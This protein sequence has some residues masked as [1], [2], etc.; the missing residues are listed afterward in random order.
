LDDDDDGLLDT[1]EAVINTDPLN[2]DTDGDTFA[3][4]DDNC[5]LVNSADQIDTDGDSE[6]DA[7]DD[8][9]DNDGLTDDLE[10]NLGTNPTLT[11][12][13]GDGDLDPDDNCPVKANPDQAD[14]DQDNQG[15]ECDLDDDNDGFTDLDEAGCG[16]NPRNEL[17]VPPDDDG[18]GV[19]NNVDLCFGDNASGDTDVDNECDNLDIDDDNDN[20][21]DNLEIACGS[22]SKLAN[23]TPPDSDND[24]IC[25][26]LDEC[27]GDDGSGDLDNDGTCNDLDDDD[28]DDG[29]SDE[30]ETTCG[31]NPL[32]AAQKPADTDSDGLCDNGVDVDDDNDGVNDVNDGAP[33]DPQFC[34]DLDGDDCDDC[35][36]TFGPPN[37]ANDGLDT[38]SDG[39]CDV[40]DIDDDD[41]GYSDEDEFT[42]GSNGL[43][44]NSLPIDTDDDGQC[45]NGVDTDDDD[46]GV[47]DALDSARTNQFQCRDFDQDDCDDCSSGI[48][49]TNQDG[50]DTD[51]DGLCNI[52]DLDD[53]GDGFDDFLEQQCESDPL[54]RLNTPPDLD[55]DTVCNKL[56]NCVDV[57]NFDQ[58]DIN[59]NNVGDACD[60]GD[61]QVAN[62]EDCD[63][64]GVDEANCNFDC[65]FAQC[66]DGHQN[67]EADEEC[68]D[69]NLNNSDDCLDDQGGL[70]RNAFCGDSFVHTF[71]EECDDGNLN[72]G[73]GCDSN[74]TNTAC[75]NGIQT[76]GEACDDDNL[77]DGDGCDSNCQFTGC[78]N[79]VVTAGEECD[80]GNLLNRDGCND[81]C[82]FEAPCHR[83]NACPDDLD[84][85]PLDA[86]VFDMGD[87]DIANASP[88]HQVTLNS[89]ELS[90]TEITV[91]QYRACV[92]AGA[93]PPPQTTNTQ[94]QKSNYQLANE[95]PNRPNKELYPMNRIT[96]DEAVTFSDW[97]G[98]RLPTESEWEY[99]ATA[100]GTNRIYAWGDDVPDC[101]LTVM[102]ENGIDGCG[103][104]LSLPVCSKSPLGNT[105]QDLCDLTGNLVEWTADERSSNYDDASPTGEAYVVDINNDPFNDR[106]RRITRGGYYRSTTATQLEVRRRFS[107]TY[108]RRTPFTGFRVARDFE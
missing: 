68:D 14:L 24:G 82:V 15:D 49:N 86:G 11:D 62:N 4:G 12:T 91:G 66:G 69:G 72:N 3:D 33:L 44:A 58:A 27:N 78:G 31:G 96:W 63:T 100:Q 76:A 38:D 105:D 92:D 40:G 13:D 26:A 71:D 80:D 65:T 106:F 61:F 30:D 74:C 103:S 1:E 101:T 35:F 94:D 29:F 23:S 5:P 36:V 46:D 83:V 81:Q 48:S 43:S 50:L 93:C 34:R 99:A 18:D 28:D 87:T 21:D 73:D 84:F 51:N 9:D 79:G 57:S 56:D 42:C 88:V 98:G 60:C 22:N 6:G 108:Y 64:G 59:G 75:G 20:F 52:G 8:D 47:I 95:S 39:R 54:Q 16:S 17:S 7:C 102:N 104:G 45:D 107:D 37:T 70:C 90:T 53:D 85:T 2:S 55:G 41:D 25:D 89:F 77:I 67:Q 97:I 32:N 10:G 19:C